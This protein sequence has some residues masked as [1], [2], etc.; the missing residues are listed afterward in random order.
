MA[1]AKVGDRVKVR[2]GGFLEDGTIFH[3]PSFEEEPLEFTIGEKRV[4]LGFENAVFGMSQGETKTASLPPEN[5]Y[6]YYT[7]DLVFL[8]EKSSIPPDI[9]LELGKRLKV[10]LQNG[11]EA[12]V[13]VKYIGEECVIFD[14][15]DPLVGEKLNFKIEL[16]EIL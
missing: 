13:T 3:S 10:T 2:Y 9:N 7:E 8:V 16:V 5:A 14:G 12:I 6:G 4:L 15:N 11:R 1:Q